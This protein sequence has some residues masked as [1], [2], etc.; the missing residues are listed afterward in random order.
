V[1]WGVGANAWQPVRRNGT[2]PSVNSMAKV[3]TRMAKMQWGELI[4]LLGVALYWVL[5][6]F[7][8]MVRLFLWDDGGD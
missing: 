2:M 6:L 4:V 7:G 5:R 1:P 8:R 3:L